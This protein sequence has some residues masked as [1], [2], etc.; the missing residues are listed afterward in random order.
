MPAGPEIPEWADPR[1]LDPAIRAALRGLDPRNSSKV[2]GHLVVAGTLLDEDPETALAHAR[3]ARDRASRLAVVREAVGVAA[4]HAGDFAEAARE[5]RAYRRMSGDQGYRAVLADCERALGRPEVA[6]RLVNEA[7]TE[8][9][10]TTE[11]VELR[12]VEAGARQDLGEDAAAKLVLEAAL[13]GRP[14]P[15]DLRA[16]DEGKL[17]L[18]AAY[19]ELLDAQGET[20][21]AAELLGAIA[22]IDPEL[23]G[24]DLGVEF[25]ELEDDE[26]E[27]DAA[28]DGEPGDDDV[29][30]HG[31]EVEQQAGVGE[32]ALILN[33]A[34]DVAAGLDDDPDDESDVAAGPGPGTSDERRL[35][36][37]EEVEA[38]VAE[39][40]GETDG[41]DADAAGGAG[42]GETTPEH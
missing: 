15:V 38:E 24:E 37:D 1:E 32:G 20:D 10:D 8:G 39:L 42:S 40:L 11:E 36:F 34:E 14:E 26:L 3:A 16:G 27:D 29:A 31:D 41:V 9:V 4:Y 19:A 21:R 30:E 6:I 18:A 5:I 25:T 12:L 35:S 13:G 23:A 7:L 33:Q 17:R 22:E 2:A 28:T